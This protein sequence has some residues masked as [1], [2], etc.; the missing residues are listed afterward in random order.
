MPGKRKATMKSNKRALDLQKEREHLL[1]VDNSFFM[2]EAY[3]ALR[4]NVT[5]AL[6]DH[7]GCKT[8]AVTS[9][10]QGEGKSLT[11]ANLAISF[12][13]AD[14]RVLVID[15]DLRRP[16]LSRLLTLGNTV[17]LSNLLLQPNLRDS[18]VLHSKETGLDVILSGDIPPNPSELLGS[19]RM[20]DLLDD[21]RQKYDCII[22]DTPPVNM[23]TD[24]SVLAPLCDGFLFVVRMN[25]S[26]K[27]A[28]LQAVDQ[29]EYAKAK[30]LGMV[31]NDVD[32]EKSGYSTYRRKYTRDGYYKSHGYGYGYGYGPQPPYH[33]DAAPEEP[34]R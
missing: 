17:G 23:V 33:Q 31:L 11:A 16:K 30:I 4:T 28:V 13:Q 10:L 2:R 1:S 3:K 27:G 8:V 5:F 20:R 34:P 7:E 12:V 19:Q 14:Q 26:E 15:C 18:A 6:A 9:A 29:L 32:M 24:A 25:W 22:L 21:L